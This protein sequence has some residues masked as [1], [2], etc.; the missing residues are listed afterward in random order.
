MPSIREQI[1]AALLARLET[2]PDATVRRE[3]PLPETV[4]AGGLIILRDGDPGD[5]EVVLSPV[6]YLWEHQTEIEIILQRGQDDD[7]AA[8]DAL[9]MTVGGALA[10]DLS[11]G[12]LAEWLDWGAP[13]TSGL[14][15]DGA[16]ALRGATVPV[17]IHY[18]SSDPLG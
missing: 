11:L 7:S 12:G 15:I 5:P 4:P 13:K 16:A 3:A 6:T 8:F 1:L 18:G 14:A 9:L 2:V 10:A 17:T